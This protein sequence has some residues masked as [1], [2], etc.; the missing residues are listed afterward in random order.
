M[1]HQFPASKSEVSAPVSSMRLTR[2]GRVVVLALG[3]LIVCASVLFSSTAVANDPDPGVEVTTATVAQGE[4]LWHLA[5]DI[6]Q[7]GEDLRDVVTLIKE[8]NDL[9]S[10]QVQIGQQ[11][12]LPA[13]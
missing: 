13:N 1:S 2:R 12:L 3:F 11:L 8:L 4:T 9:D 5:R 7:P 6:A 10:S